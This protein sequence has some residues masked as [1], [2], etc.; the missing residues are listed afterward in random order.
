MK[1]RKQHRRDFLKT[2]I[3]ATTAVAAP[4]FF[5][6][7]TPLAAYRDKGDEQA[8]AMLAR[9]YRKGFEIEM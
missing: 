6:P 1:N 7:P 9:E 2:S 8:N 3:V 5:Y 4:Y